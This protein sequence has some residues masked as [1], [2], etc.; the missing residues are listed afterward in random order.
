VTRA[1][2]DFA[3][4][5]AVAGFKL[6]QICRPNGDIA[7]TIVA[8]MPAARDSATLMAIGR[9]YAAKHPS[10]AG[11]EVV[12][13]NDSARATCTFPMDDSAMAAFVANYTVNR[14]RGDR[15]EFLDYALGQRPSDR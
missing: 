2:E 8:G 6:A 15:P 11:V 4:A 10:A 9:S 13:F 14:L 1:A 5:A 3:R 12:F 7:N